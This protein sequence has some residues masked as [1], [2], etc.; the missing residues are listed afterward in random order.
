[1]NV[2]E[3][4]TNEIRQLCKDAEL[5]PLQGVHFV[6]DGK[7]MMYLPES[8][9]KTIRLCIPHI[10]NSKDYDEKRLITLLNETNREVKFIKVFIL[11]NGSVS[12][13][14]DHK[15]M[16]GERVKDIVPYMIRSLDF[17]SDYLIRKMKGLSH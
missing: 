3:E 5:L 6:Y 8:D 13:N 15:F 7:H 16:K 14:Y 17:A 12:L 2:Q 4:I 10:A 1:M 9:G 11:K